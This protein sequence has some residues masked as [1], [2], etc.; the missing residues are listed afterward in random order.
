MNSLSSISLSGMNAAMLRL[1]AAGNNIAN[2]QTPGYMRQSVQQTED[3]GG[4]VS[5]LAARE[6]A[7]SEN[8]A[9]DMVEQVSAVYSF[10]ANLRVLQAQDQMLGVLV[11]LK[12]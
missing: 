2:A 1:D 12:A 5:T 8:L 9:A 7:P 3:A 10:K 4:G 6:A 11:D